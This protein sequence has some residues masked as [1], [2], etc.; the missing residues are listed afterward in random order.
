[1]KPIFNIEI[2]TDD[3]EAIAQSV[4]EENEL[5]EFTFEQVK[6]AVYCYLDNKVEGLRDDALADA[7]M[8]DHS[9]S[10]W[11]PDLT[12]SSSPSKNGFRLQTH[13]EIEA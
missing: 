1:M 5:N 9:I 10:R 13:V 2:T 3:I 6:Y 11:L 7:H 12:V 4:F 8:L